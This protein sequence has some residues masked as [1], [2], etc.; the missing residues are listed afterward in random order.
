MKLKAGLLITQN[1]KDHKKLL[2]N[3]IPTNNLEAMDK[4]LR[5]YKQSTLNHEN[6]NSEPI[7]S[8]DIETVIKTS[9]QIK[10]RSRCFHW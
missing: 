2:I 6:I 7:V 4:F 5:A 10:S 1:Y 8:K 9:Q 3:C